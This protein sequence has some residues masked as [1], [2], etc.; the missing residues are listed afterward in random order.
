MLRRYPQLIKQAYFRIIAMKRA[1]QIVQRV[2]AAPEGPFSI[3]PPAGYRRGIDHF[4]RRMLIRVMANV[5]AWYRVSGGR[6]PDLIEPT[7]Y[8][9]KLNHAKFFA[10]MKIPETGNK[11]LTETFIPD[12]LV[13]TV[14]YP[15]IVWRS[16]VAALPDNDAVLPGV[17]YLKTNHGSG[18]VR[19]IEYPLSR[20]EKAS[21]EREFALFLETDFGIE[22]G[23]WW[24]NTFERE[25]LLEEAVT[26]RNPSTAIL[27]FVI[28]GA[29]RYISVDQKALTAGDVTKTL[30]LNPDF[31]VSDVQRPEPERMCDV[32]LS[33]DLKTALLAVAEDIGGQFDCVRVDLMV[34]DD[35]GIYL[36]ELTHVSNAGH[37]FHDRRMDEALGRAWTGRAIYPGSR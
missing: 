8:S 10:A 15:P 34:G 30:L 5:L 32:D 20:S 31:T 36:N 9:E 24:Y 7:S 21:L 2:A 16:P 17:Y 27:F 33:D 12:H 26:S 6:F 25:L 19:R 35:G 3:V 14:R 29:V 11:S 1:R 4:D 13:G 37:P 28:G 23:E 22:L 18:W